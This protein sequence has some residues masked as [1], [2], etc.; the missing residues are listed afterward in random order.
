MKT[1]D[2]LGRWLFYEYTKSPTQEFRPDARQLRWMQFLQLHGLAST[3]Y[4][5]KYTLATH[6]CPQTS[7]RQLRKLFDGQMIYK[8]R[9]QRETA[10]ADGN[11]TIKPTP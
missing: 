3:K 8:P 2:H 4:L 6:R 11:Q 5:H 7:N 9:Q 1:H 10:N